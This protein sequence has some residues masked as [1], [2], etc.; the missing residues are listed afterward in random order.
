MMSC[1]LAIS[2]WTIYA[3]QTNNNF[4]LHM[5]LSQA[6]IELD[7]VLHL[8]HTSITIKHF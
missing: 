7:R 1:L 4:C 5:P 6:T 2:G 8:M 3:T